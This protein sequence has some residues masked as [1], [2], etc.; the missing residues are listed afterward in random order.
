MI[1]YLGILLISLAICGC[2]IN[3][4]KPD[5]VFNQQTEQVIHNIAFNQCQEESSNADNGD[6]FE[7]ASRGLHIWIKSNGNFQKVIA[8]NSCL[9]TVIGG[10]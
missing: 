8:D 10:Q 2:A 4:C 5:P 3:M 1:N 9:I 6:C 7:D